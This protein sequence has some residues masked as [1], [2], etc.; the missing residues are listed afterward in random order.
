MLALPLIEPFKSLRAPIDIYW[1]GWDGHLAWYNF[2]LVILYLAIIA[3]GLGSAWKR[4]RWL[5]LAPLAF[6]L[7]Y[8]LGKWDC[9]FLRMAI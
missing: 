5:G 6:S 7:G 1:F 9:P 4:L 2:L 8:A 3:I